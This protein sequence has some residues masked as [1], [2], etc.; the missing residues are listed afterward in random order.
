MVDTYLLVT[1]P[2]PKVHLYVFSPFSPV[3]SNVVQDLV[4]DKRE[5]LNITHVKK[6]IF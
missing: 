1:V 4:H 2:M 5:I 6:Y 3:H